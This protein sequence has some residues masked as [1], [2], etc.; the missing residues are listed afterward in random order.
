[1]KEKIECSNCKKEFENEKALEQ[2]K[3]RKHSGQTTSKS[4]NKISSLKKNWKMVGVGLFVL[5]LLFMFAV[6]TKPIENDSGVSL[7]SPIH[8][9]PQVSITIDGAP[10]EIPPNIGI[11]AGG[12]FPIHTHEPDGVLH[13]EQSSP[14]TKTTALAQ[15]FE[16]WGKTFT[17]ECILDSCNDGT[18]SM[19]M[20]VNGE[21]N[22]DFENYQMNDGDFIEIIYE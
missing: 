18:K 7:G 22:S 5:W 1:M 10:I 17:A 8:W 16:I 15:F 3:Q 2:H 19:N 14:T 21:P 13:V 6:N 9:H 12:H 20:L 11:G 4:S